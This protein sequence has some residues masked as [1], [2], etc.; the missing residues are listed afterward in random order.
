M[1]KKHFLKIIL[2]YFVFVIGLVLILG[3]YVWYLN[4]QNLVRLKLA[5][6][7]FPYARYSVEELEKMYP[8]YPNENVATVQTPE[9][10]YAKFIEALKKG[11]VEGAS[12]QFVAKDE[13]KWLDVFKK[14]KEN[15]LLNEYLQDYNKSLQKIFV[16]NTF[17]QFS[18]IINNVGRPVDFVK[19]PEGIW[20]IESL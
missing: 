18:I 17:A 12:K 13:G 15:N 6:P 2:Y 1:F 9:Q 19:D 8:Q 7:E 10:T 20:K 3:G 5:R 16:Y 11:D 14:I 4:K